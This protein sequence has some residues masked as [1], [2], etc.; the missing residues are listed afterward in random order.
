MQWT[1]MFIW[2]ITSFSLS[3]VIHFILFYAFSSF[4]ENE[5]H[6]LDTVQQKEWERER[7]RM[8]NNCWKMCNWLFAVWCEKMKSRRK[9]NEIDWR[10]ENSNIFQKKRKFLCYGTCNMT[11]SWLSLHHC[12]IISFV[13]HWNCLLF[14]GRRSF[15]IFIHIRAWKIEQ[16]MRENIDKIPNELD[17]CILSSSGI[18]NL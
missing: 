10:R 9:R 2:L 3:L 8:D 6:S 12:H 11:T 17:R 1:K 4:I 16:K 13:L 15:V 7:N 18:N 5:L 14:F